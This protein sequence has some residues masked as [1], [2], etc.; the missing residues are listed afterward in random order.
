MIKEFHDLI[1]LFIEKASEFNALLEK[2]QEENS[3]VDGYARFGFSSS[4]LSRII[5]ASIRVYHGMEDVDYYYEHFDLTKTTKESLTKKFDDAFNFIN[6]KEA[7]AE[8]MRKYYE[9][10]IEEV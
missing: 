3:S 5:T 6:N 10:K 4:C 9:S 8:V 1:Y 7:R 2:S